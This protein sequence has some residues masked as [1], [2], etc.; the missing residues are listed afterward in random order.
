[1][2]DRRRFLWGIAQ[3]IVAIVVMIDYFTWVPWLKAV[4]LSEVPP[5]V[6]ATLPRECPAAT[7]NR[8]RWTCFSEGT[9]SSNPIGF[10]ISTVIMIGGCSFLVF[11]GLTNRG[12]R[13]R[14]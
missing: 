7:K 13:L 8:G 4:P 6:V 1:M 14:K 12:M 11:T 3:T 5:S 9:I 10:A 2:I